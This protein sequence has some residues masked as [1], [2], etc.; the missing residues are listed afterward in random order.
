MT[1]PPLGLPVA[2]AGLLAVVLVGVV[3][4]PGPVNGVAPVQTAVVGASVV[5]PAV[6]QQA[7]LATRVSAGT[8]GRT[9][10]GTLVAAELPAVTGSVPPAPPPAPVEATAGPA[11]VTAGLAPEVPDAALLLSAAGGLAAGLVVEQLSRAPSGP[12]RGLEVVGCAAPRR[13]TWFAGGSLGPDESTDLV[14]ANPDDVA[15]VVDVTAWTDAG[16]ADPRPGRGL[17]VPP[18]SRTTL[19]LD[20][21][22]PGRTGLAVRVLAERGRVAAAVEHLRG[23]ALGADWVPVTSP[24]TTVP[25]PGVPAGPGPRTLLVTNPG[26]APTTVEV[27]ITTADRQY[28]PAGLDALAVPAGTTVTADLTGLV[29]DGPATVV[30]T[31]GAG[32]V[33]AVAL[34][35]DG[36]GPV[37]DIAYAG[38]VG[39]LTGPALV[40][41]AGGSAGTL[42]LTA[43]GGD[44]S[45]VLSAVPVAGAVPLAVPPPRTVQVRGGSTVAVPLA[46]FGLPGDGR[47]AL[48]VRPSGAPLEAAVL[49]REDLV[50]GPATALLPLVAPVAVVT[51]PPVQPDPGAALH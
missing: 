33:L 39:P 20:T 41:D 8:A 34:A 10:P 44:A 46:S 24:G 37:Q 43:L 2:V 9:G 30:V 12:H 13:E 50:D 29:A 1:R 45:V 3:T 51:R 17:V 38:A 6:R 21:L 49:L 15:A 19:P 7:D 23:P 4:T 27:Q 22:A 26:D 11:A 36:A 48:E 32:P 5:C 40:P 42:A 47:F 16:A 25:V 28:V 35:V 18:R 31:S 14:L